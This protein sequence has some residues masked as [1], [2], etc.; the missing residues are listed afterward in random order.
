MDDK[1][2]KFF[3][4]IITNKVQAEYIKGD[5]KAQ[6][7]H[8]LCFLCPEKQALVEIYAAGVGKEWSR[9]M[10]R[11]VPNKH[12]RLV[13]YAYADPSEEVIGGRT[14]HARG[15]KDIVWRGELKWENDKG[16]WEAFV[17]NQGSNLT[18]CE[19]Q[20]FTKIVHLFKQFF[21]ENSAR[22]ITEI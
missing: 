6:V 20:Q 5:G 10:G 19:R 8:V 4:L 9:G 2:G 17:V 13:V 18:D 1:L 15:H 22:F 11:A 16:F 21:R 7:E 14:Y 12:N 3:E